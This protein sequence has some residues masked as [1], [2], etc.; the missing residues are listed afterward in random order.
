MLNHGLYFVD[1][2]SFLT[3]EVV[4]VSLQV[5]HVTFEDPYSDAIITGM[6]IL[7]YTC[8][9]CACSLYNKCLSCVIYLF[10]AEFDFSDI[11]SMRC[12]MSN[13][14]NTV[15]FN[16]VSVDDL[17]TKIFHRQVFICLQR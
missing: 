8:H 6:Y 10:A 17:A 5:I 7:T 13:H 2:S 3:F 16:E 14:G 15:V 9:I 4:P 1:L 12:H 11:T